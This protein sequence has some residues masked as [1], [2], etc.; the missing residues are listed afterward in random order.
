MIERMLPRKPA[1]LLR[2]LASGLALILLPLALVL[3]WLAYQGWLLSPGAA[4]WLDGLSSFASVF[5]GIFI[6]AVPFLLL[7]TLAS[8]LVEAF[9][10]PDEIRRLAGLSAWR[11]ALAGSL[12]GLAVPVCECGVVPLTRRL[13]RKGLPLPAGVAFLLASPVINP[14]T[15]ASTLAAFGPGALLGWRLGLTFAIALLTGLMFALLPGLAHSLR[16]AEPEPLSRDTHFSPPPPALTRHARL[17][18]AGG[19]A[20]DEFFEMGQFLVLGALLAALLQTVVPRAALLALNQGVLLPAVGM[21]ALAV[22]LSICSTVDAFVAL[23]FANTFSLGSLL[24]FLV[25]GPMVDLKSLLLYSRV[26]TRRGWL[27]LAGLPLALVLL[28]AALLNLAAAGG[29]P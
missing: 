18:L 14:I 9:I 6:E 15:I 27:A 26:F 12:L 25:Y 3:L 7:G 24:A 8:G 13:L 2:R 19:V 4:A 21:S 28:A 5:L 11:A 16:P 17:R 29:M 10:P 23:A 1:T 22:L 20:V